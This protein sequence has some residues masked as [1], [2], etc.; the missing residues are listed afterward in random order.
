ML[1]PS[2]IR[3]LLAYLIKPYYPTSEVVN[4]SDPQHVSTRKA[5]R[6]AH[7]ERTC[8][9]RNRRHDFVRQPEGWTKASLRR[10]ELCR[11]L[12]VGR[13]TLREAVACLIF[14]GMLKV[15][16][17]EGTF[18]TE[19]PTRMFDQIVGHGIFSTGKD[20]SDLVHTRLVLETETASLCA[21]YASAKDLLI[22]ESLLERMAE[23]AESGSDD[24]LN[25]D[26]DFHMAIAAGSG[27]QILSHLLSTI[28][29]LLGQYISQSCHK[30]PTP[31]RVAYYQ[32]HAAILD[33]LRKRNS[34]KARLE[35]QKHLET[36]FSEALSLMQAT[37]NG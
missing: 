32:Q 3:R 17:G 9:P 30:C 21:K 29:G 5:P 24:F 10:P 27:N 26:V 2:D 19:G 22:L 31:A 14:I 28:R 8:G 25:L 7:A 12:G 36:G 6:P 4:E 13:S 18:V 15:R 20:I 16:A 37:Q 11:A 33:A 23:S 1:H 35:M 34:R